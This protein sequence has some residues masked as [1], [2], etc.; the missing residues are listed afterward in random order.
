MSARFVKRLLPAVCAAA[1]AVAAG[2]A[3]TV[4]EFDCAESHL[5]IGADGR[6]KSLVEKATGREL[7]RWFSK[8]ATVVTADG[9]EHAVDRVEALS[10]ERIRLTFERTDG[11]AEISV[12][13]EPWGF[14]FTAEGLT[15][16]QPK[17]FWFFC[18]Y[19][20]CRKWNG[21]M[22]NAMSDEKSAIV[23]RAYELTTEM[24]NRG[25]TVLEAVAEVCAHR[26]ALPARAA[27]VAAPRTRILD[28][29]K[30]VTRDAGA[31]ETPCGG[32]W[33]LSSPVNRD[34]YLIAHV[35]RESVEDWISLAKRGGFS[36]ISFYDWWQTLGH[37]RTNAKSFPRGDADLKVSIDLIH[38]AGLKCGMHTL[39]ACIDFND[40]WTRPVCHGDMLV[41]ANYTLARPFMD[42]DTE[43][44]V[45][46][47]PSPKHDFVNS[48]L[49]NG[50]N[51]RIGEELFTYTGLRGDAAP[52]AF[53]GVRRAAHGTRSAG[54]VPV[55]ARVEYLFQHFF[56]F[57]PEP[58]SP[59]MDE[60]AALLAKRYSDF[61]FDFVYHDGA[62]PM[63]RY[64]VD[65]TRRKFTAA[66]DRSS[67]P[68]QVEASI[69]GAHNWWFHSRLG[70]WD[71]PRWAAKRFHDVHLAHCREEVVNANML[72]AQAG[73]WS[74]R[75]ADDACR[76]HFTD[77]AEYFASQ[78][79][80]NGF[81]MSVDGVSVANGPLSFSV[82]RQ[83]TIIG[84]YERFRRAQAF[85]DEAVRRLAEPRAEFRLAQNL[86]SGAWELA[87]TAVGVHRAHTPDF[88]NWDFTLPEARRGGVRVEALY[89]AEPDGGG[90]L[91]GPDDAGAFAYSSA[92]GVK[93]AATAATDAGR[94]RVLRLRAENANA[95][96]RGSWAVAGL[97]YAHPFRDVTGGAA[98]RRA[99]GFW[100][101][102]DGSGAVLALRLVSPRIH[103][104]GMSPHFVRLD[105]TGWRRVTAFLRER[106][107]DA[108]GDFA[109]PG[110]YPTYLV[111]RD[112]V[113]PNRLERIEFAFNDV[114]ASG[115]AEVLVSPVEV[116]SEK[117]MSVAGGAVIINGTEHR[118]P[119]ALES[120]E[121]AE[122]EGGI[123][124]R[125]SEGGEPQAAVRTAEDVL[126]SAGTNRCS[127]AGD[128]AA[129]VEVTLMARGR[130]F[131][132]LRPV[133]G[134]PAETRAAMTYEALDPVLY[135]PKD[136]LDRP[137][138]LATRPGESAA[139]EFEIA[140]PVDSPRFDLRSRHA[141]SLSFALPVKLAAG[142]RLIVRNGR[143]WRVVRDF[144]TVRSGRLEQAIPTIS[145]AYGVRVTSM[146]PASARARIEIV[147]RYGE[148]QGPDIRISKER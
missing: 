133:D 68:L 9:A 93:I 14:V 110:Y 2:A 106:D 52:Y 33:S 138:Q 58:S 67:R 45:N 7:L 85:T 70:A 46:E 81:A 61:G 13:C 53:T 104:G 131:P 62:E 95:S 141:D 19:P 147:K 43:L 124:T 83:M 63:S 116:L 66:M 107:A 31:I 79:A 92:D 50:N 117:K 90:I 122:L 119:F 44:F 82:E 26:D 99:F 88:R 128:E 100:V 5:V 130:A 65:L 94:G 76:G 91:V 27:L 121:Y 145:G 60:M 139:L 59:F 132:A 89:A 137:F 42:G 86:A 109:W 41:L 97:K 148:W 47:K 112:L 20:V 136:G 101:K 1:F 123:W 146:D 6:L 56:S 102:G 3:E 28:L 115:A 38:A 140:G 80:G 114:P 17:E 8:F 23:L 57:F 77:E 24:R 127:F 125:F 25:N 37:Y 87:P 30:A 32:A 15:V 48:F 108:Y 54:T 49:S 126:I 98:S 29:M 105:F 134:L 51:L 16:P 73:W 71:H 75:R 78:N 103:N 111:H 74:P 34:S 129:R 96:R 12:R 64:N 84:R 40:A 69:G 21:A 72:A 55:G 118:L 22:M 35:T 10:K 11:A 144:K 113:F 39:T 143:D 36:V 4:A 18:V 135:A 120:G 142:E